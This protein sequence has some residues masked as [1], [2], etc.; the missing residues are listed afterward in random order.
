MHA[1]N[2]AA[3]HA[4]HGL[5]NSHE[6]RPSCPSRRSQCTMGL[7]WLPSSGGVFQHRV[8]FGLRVC[9][10]L[11]VSIQ[12]SSSERGR[13]RIFTVGV[14]SGKAS[15]DST[16]FRRRASPE[17]DPAILPAMISAEVCRAPA[18]RFRNSASH[19]SQLPHSHSWP[20]AHVSLP[21]SFP[22][23]LHRRVCRAPVS[24]RAAFTWSV[25]PHAS[26]PEPA[27]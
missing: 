1:P 2:P 5:S 16:I 14:I 20:T 26:T 27:G 23:P 24:A 25:E 4:G 17:L 21:H 19:A 7:P 18:S 22:V 12:H 8:A 9:G 13:A 10:T 3:L 15:R 11:I 6:C